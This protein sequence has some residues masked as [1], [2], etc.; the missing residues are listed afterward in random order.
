M[1]VLT[2]KLQEQIRVGDNITLTVLRVKGNS[3]RIG[4]EAPKDVRVVR[5]E[6]PPKE[7]LEA[8]DELPPA[9]ITLQFQEELPGE[10]SAEEPN[11]APERLT[12]KDYMSGSAAH[13]L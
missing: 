2:R 3:V 10:S 13:A 7:S 4:I 8:I 1:L 6:L 5:G 12:L 9:E 11:R